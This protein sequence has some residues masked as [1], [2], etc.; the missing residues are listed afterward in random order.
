MQVKLLLE[1]D[2]S[3]FVGWQIQDKNK[4]KKPSI[5]STLQEA[6][7]K[8]YK[9]EIIVTGC[10]RT[11][12]NVNA[13]SYCATYSPPFFIPEINLAKAINSK[14]LKFDRKIRVNSCAY[15]S[16]DFH[17]RYNAKSKVYIYKIFN[18]EHKNIFDSFSYFLSYKLKDE[19]FKNMHECCKLFFGEHDF[20]GFSLFDTEK[21]TE[22][23]TIAEIF[24]ID[25]KKFETVKGVNIYFVIRGNRFLHKMI[26][27]IVGAI[28][29]VGLKHLT[30]EQVK[31][32]LDK[33]TR[34]H[35]INIVPGN[36]L[37]LKRV[38][39]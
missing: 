12:S 29:A 20:R 25:M 4:P 27:F 26:R 37:F 30:I 39:Y 10:S 1:F 5:Q 7:K 38:Y 28:L 11:D 36:G 14:F 34:K 18:A 3:G 31:E 23:N 35:K 17:P 9:Q 2:G 6:L 15:V 33:G 21:F 16:D 32:N 19:D 22:K 8:I 24:Y 13:K